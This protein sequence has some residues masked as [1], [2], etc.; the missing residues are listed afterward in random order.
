MPRRELKGCSA[1]S[2]IRC[3]CWHA[4]SRSSPVAHE[5]LCRRDFVC[6]AMGA[7][8]S[9]VS[10]TLLLYIFFLSQRTKS[11]QPQRFNPQITS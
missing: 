3:C 8:R 1:F 6:G 5:L 2:R 11:F 10:V 4:E 9:L 7:I